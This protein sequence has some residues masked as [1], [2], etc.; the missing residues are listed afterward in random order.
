MG[1]KNLYPLTPS[2]WSLSRKLTWVVV[3]E[4]EPGKVLGEG[5]MCKE[6]EL[7]P[8]PGT[9]AGLCMTGNSIAKGR[10]SLE[11]KPRSKGI[12]HPAESLSSSLKE[13]GLYFP[14][15]SVAPLKGFMQTSDR[16]R[17]AFQP[18]TLAGERGWKAGGPGRRL[19]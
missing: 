11:T 14:E 8:L 9:E 18:V 12:G 5:D 10:R 3:D 2:R 17:L 7:G 16:I 6:P 1:S 15:G 13:S 4:G 19:L